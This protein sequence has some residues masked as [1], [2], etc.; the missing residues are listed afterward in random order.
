M[1]RIEGDLDVL[2]I[3]NLLQALTMSRCEG[4]FSVT[5][6]DRKK[7]IR[8]GPQGIRLLSGSE[9]VSPLGE[10]LLRT[11]KI[12]RGQLAEILVDHP[13]SG[14]PLGEYVAKNGIL[15]REDIDK[16]LKE[17]VA[18]EIYDLFTWTGGRFEFV[19]ATEAP[20]P[21]EEEILSSV[22]LDQNVMFIALEAA[23][24][25]DQLARI[26]EVIPGERL[27]P[28]VHEIPLSVNDPGLDR[29]SVVEIL[30]FVDGRRSVA[31][32]IDESLYPKFTVLH[33]L[34]A[35]AQRGAVKIRDVGAP[36]GPE[37]VHLRQAPE[38]GHA[39]DRD[40]A[41]VL[42]LSGN[43]VFRLTVSL[44]LRNLNFNVVECA[45]SED[46][47][48]MIVKTRP[49]VMLLDIPIETDDGMALCGRLRRGID[50]PFVIMTDVAGRRTV[51]NAFLSGARHVLLKPVNLDLL[52]ERLCEVLEWRKDGGRQGT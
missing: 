15:T 11:R 28:V 39:S 6:D 25:M 16:A 20:S 37:T 4:Y 31:Q 10:I 50:V 48:E 33:T 42:F 29:D 38:Q 46:L 24:R 49:E 18:D 36:D 17:Q 32:I 35:M 22:T 40:P 13:K 45:T 9:R 21:A 43:T 52:S 44:C 14:R 2:G 47:P 30:P 5:K 51:S 23:R 3:A 19:D 8:F 7:V 12:T 26:R 41:A 1:G 34:Y 27:V